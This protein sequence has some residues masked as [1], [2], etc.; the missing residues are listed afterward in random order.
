M[1]WSESD[2]L[3]PVAV[4]FDA[5]AHLINGLLDRVDVLFV[6]RQVLPVQNAL[7]FVVCAFRS[8]REIS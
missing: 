7:Y 3:V 6:S 5:G 2:V 8:R 4:V 1:R